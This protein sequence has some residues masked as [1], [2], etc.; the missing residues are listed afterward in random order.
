M[1]VSPK[2]GQREPICEPWIYIVNLCAKKTFMQNTFDHAIGFCHWANGWSIWKTR[3]VQFAK[4]H[5]TEVNSDV[6]L[7]DVQYWGIEAELIPCLYFA[8]TIMQFFFLIQ[9]KPQGPEQNCFV[10]LT[11]TL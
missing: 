4:K 10:I 5:P 8:P 2:N 11:R 7:L 1:V 9:P 3:L 6:C